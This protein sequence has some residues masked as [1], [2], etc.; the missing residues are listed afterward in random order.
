MKK[1]SFSKKYRLLTGG[2]VVCLFLIGITYFSLPDDKVH[3]YF[4]DVGQGD[5][6]LIKT[7]ANYKILVDGGPDSKSVNLLGSTLPFWDRKIDLLV[8]THPD[9][10][11]IKGLT[12]VINS[13]Q[14][15]QIWFSNVTNDTQA[16][17][18]INAA[19]KR[20]KIAVY[21][22][23]RGDKME[24]PDGSQLKV[25][26]P[27]DRSPKFDLIDETSLVLQFTYQHFTTLLT[28]DALES[29]QPYP[30]SKIPTTVLKVAH[31][32]ARNGTSLSY[33]QLI[34]PEISVISAG[35]GN[36]YGHPDP[37]T[38][39]KLKKVGTKI[40][41]TINN[42]TVEVVSDGKSWYTRTEK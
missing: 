18:E 27:K 14:V 38:L 8:A 5:S 25:L 1:A 7:V 21:A 12:V 4:F 13:Y 3:S 26:W 32:G 6:I 17:K 40:Y 28:G 37:L 10:D 39:D 9:S 19:I 41:N 23:I 20:K 35:K 31:H 2:L 16:F 34:K 30:D 24:F 33:L 22:P 36:R 29:T 11:H 42:G 15:N